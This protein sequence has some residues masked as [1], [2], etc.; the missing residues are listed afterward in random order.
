MSLSTREERALRS[1]KEWLT[2]SDPKLA[3]LLATFTRLVAGEDMPVRERIP[4]GWSRAA[5]LPRHQRPPHRRQTSRPIGQVR[6]RPSF[7]QA[8]MLLWVVITVVFVIVALILSRG[9]SG[10]GCTTAWPAVCTRTTPAQVPGSAAP[11]TT[12]SQVHPSSG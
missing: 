6:W 2:S 3:A 12:V 11:R 1:I 8:A 7:Q 4:T 5:S 10:G 9:G